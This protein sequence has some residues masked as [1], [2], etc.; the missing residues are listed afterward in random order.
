MTARR[1]QLAQRRR[2]A[3]YSQEQLA[4]RLGIE[5]STVSRWERGQTEPQPWF[6]PKLADALAVSGEELH[7]LLLNNAELH[8]QPGEDVEGKVPFDPMRRRTFVKW[9]L[10]TPVVTGLGI[11]SV[12]KVGAADVARLQHTAA[13]LY[14]LTDQHGGDTLW[15]AAMAGVHEGRLMLERGTYSP[16]VGQQLL[17]ATA[18]LQECAG[19]LAFDAGQDNVAWASYT[20]ALALARQ[21]NDREVELWALA[22]LARQSFVVGQPREALRL[23]TAAAQVTAA[24]GWSPRLAAIPH[25]RRAVAS[26]LVADARDA[27][28]AIIQARTVLDRDHDEPSDEASAFLGPAEL[29]GI[30]ATCALELGRVSRAETLLEQAITGY[31][32]RFARNRA[33]CRVRLARARLDM[34]EIE[35]AAEAATGALYDLSGGLASWRVSSELDAVARRL[36]EYSEV[37]DVERFLADYRTMSR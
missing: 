3:G 27:D 25:L 10:A 2:A 19:W 17:M 26:A 21:A 5:R 4:E 12:A 28:R 33:L 30:E 14:R 6:R 13:R 29:D 34:N 20:D 18:R 7:E 32:S 15:Q 36:A 35:G 16:N 37:T 1:E 23:A 9:G 22:N 8:E 24:V 11:G 31:G